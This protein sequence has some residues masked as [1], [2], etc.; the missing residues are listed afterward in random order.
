MQGGRGFYKMI[1]A[2]RGFPLRAS[3]GPDAPGATRDANVALSSEDG[4]CATCGRPSPH[5][6]SPGRCRL[7]DMT[8]TRNHGRDLLEPCLFL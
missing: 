3:L 5:C 1:E 6:G 7:Y 4:T 2:S 8:H